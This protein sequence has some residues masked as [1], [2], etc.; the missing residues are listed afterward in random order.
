MTSPAVVYV[1]QNGTVRLIY[2]DALA[3]LARSLGP[4]DVRRASHVEPDPAGLWVADMAPVG[5]PSLGPYETRA[6]ALEAE[7][8][9][10]TDHGIP[11]PE[12]R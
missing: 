9:W 11:W 5:G 12:K 10:L 7:T 3:P 2:A 4:I 6:E 8:Q 1:D